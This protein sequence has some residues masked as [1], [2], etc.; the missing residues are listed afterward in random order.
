MIRTGDQYRE[1]IRDGREVWVDGERVKDVADHPMFKPIVD[2]RARIYDLAHDEA[3]QDA[4]TYV[5]LESGERN[6]IANKLPRT[7]QDWLDKRAAVDL[8]LED[9]RG[10]VTRVGDE[11]IGEMWSL[12]D[13]Q[14]VLNEVD[15][16]FSEN[17]RRHLERSVREDPFHVSANTDP[18]GDRSKAPQDQDPDMLLHVVKETDNGIVVRGAKYETAAAYS[19]QAFTK[20]TIANWGNSELSDYA[21]GFVLDMGAPGLKYISRNGFAGR[22]PAADYPLANRVDEVESLVVFDNVEIPWEDVLFYRHTRAAWFIRSTLHRYSAF[23][24]VQ[25]TLHLAD[26]MIGSALWNV[27]Q[28]GLEKQQ[29]VQEKLA[30]LACYRETINAHLTAAISLAEPSPGGLLMPNQSLLYTGRVMALSQLPAMMHIARELCGGQICI[31]PDAATFADTDV[32]PWLE[33]FYSIND[34]WVADDRRKLLAFARDLL[35]SDYAG[36]RLTFQLFAQSPPFAQLAAVYRN[37][38]F[39]GPLGLVKAAAGLSDNVDGGVA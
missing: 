26:L 2:V 27:K 37:F 18:K 36:H 24:F 1:S 20:P 39:D 19:N 23:P 35:N 21:V 25:R 29:A 12:F 38:D 13:G 7:Q 9:T 32:A 6:A 30:Q 3:T 4:M 22:A 14:D 17:I 34:N 15:P 5:D 16:R 11:T 28:S 31:T 33:K 10:V 8:V